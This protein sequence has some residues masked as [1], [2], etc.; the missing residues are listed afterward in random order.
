MRR[1]LLIAA[2]AMLI[3]GVSGFALAQSGYLSIPE[4]L[5]IEYV[6]SVNV[7]DRD[8][9]FADIAT[10]SSSDQSF[11]S[12]L[13]QTNLGPS[14]ST[15]YTRKLT[16]GYIELRLRQRKIDPN[17][18]PVPLPAS[19]LVTSNRPAA[20]GVSSGAPAT[21]TASVEPSPYLVKRGDLVRVVVRTASAEITAVGEARADG[22]LGDMVEVRNVDTGKRFTGR[23][24]SAG[25]VEVTNGG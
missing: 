22:R 6:S 13:G 8:I 20:G 7:V 2:V 18:L 1:V 9:V 24:V 12:I 3:A 11:V 15:G 4:D 17:S 10:I 16:S 23:V 14:P 25:V 19:V 5:T 21:G